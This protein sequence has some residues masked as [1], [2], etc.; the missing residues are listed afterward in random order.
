MYRISHPTCALALSA[1]M[2]LGCNETPERVRIFD[3]GAT[4]APSGGLQTRSFAL[5]APSGAVIA[6]GMSLQHVGTIEAPVVDDFVVQATDLEFVGSRLIA[7]Y[8]TE[9]EDLRGALQVI[10]LSDPE[11]PQVLHEA[12][13]P[14]T[15]LNRMQVRH[16]ADGESALLYIAGADA[17]F[18]ATLDVFHVGPGS[19]LTHETLVDLP[20]YHSTML[21]VQ[22]DR[23]YAVTGDNGGL[24]VLD[25][26]VPTEP[27]IIQYLPL[28]D[29]RFVHP[30][31][32]RRPVDIV[33]AIDQSGS[34]GDTIEAVRGQLNAFADAISAYD[35]DYRVIILAAR[36]NDPDDHELCVPEPLAGPNCGDGSRF[37]QIDEHVDSHDAL[38]KIM[39]HFDEIEGFLRPDSRRHFVVVTDDKSYVSAGQFEDFLAQ[40]DGFDDYVFHSIVGHKKKKGC[41]V[42]KGQHYMSLSETTGGLVYNVC[43]ADWTLLVDELGTE[44]ATGEELVL[45]TGK[46]GVLTRQA[47]AGQGQEWEPPADEAAVPGT[48]IGA[49]TWGEVV[50]NTVY[51][52]A[53]TAGVVVYDA[54]TG[55]MDQVKV[56]PTDGDANGMAL[57]DDRRLA[58]LA[59]GQ[60]GL[61]IVDVLD[62]ENS[63]ILTVFDVEDSGSANAVAV[64]GDLVAL[65]DG[66]GGIKV[67]RYAL[68]APKNT[69]ENHDG[70]GEPGGDQHDG[71]N[72]E[73]EPG[74]DES[75]DESDD[76]DD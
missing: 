64:H 1:L 72:G 48:A 5:K 73:D 67:F 53:D 31:A 37:L 33:W 17:E 35:G 20:S 4:T 40:R 24:V 7:T 63:N 39:E 26:G 62:S 42:N 25:I 29:A 51:V 76:D 57:T 14:G 65:A 2:A 52:S 69:E 3:G 8:N 9:G 75:D 58:F 54:S 56:M 30:F 66:L 44:I 32:P 18:Q 21:A 74:D 59:N 23:A 13:L 27:Q 38:D 15:D 22:G 12:L 47:V 28:P 16:T 43:N 70:Q 49:P 34:M 41:S 55:T 71:D 36:T 11:V 61:V 6:D 68:V 50:G 19:G 46:P 10:D 45:V 60:E